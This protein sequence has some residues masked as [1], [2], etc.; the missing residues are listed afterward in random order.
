[1]HAEIGAERLVHLILENDANEAHH[2][3]RG[4]YAAQW[5]DDI[6]H[7]LHVLCTGEKDGYYADYAQAPIA[8]LGRCLAEGFAYQGERSAYRDGA[9][10]GEASAYLR[11]QAFVSF[12]QCHD[13]VGNRAFG[14]RITRLAPEPAVRVAVAVY[15]LAPTVPMLFMGEEFAAET[16]FQFFCD[17][18]DEL[19][20]TVTQGRRREFRKFARFADP[21]VLAAIPDP[22]RA[23]TF[24]A[25]KLDWHSLKE[26]KHANWLAYYRSLLRLRR[27]VIVPRLRGM[28][29]HAAAFDVLAPGALRVEWRL[30]DGSTLRLQTNFSAM[31][32][33]TVKPAGRTV[34]ASSAD[35]AKGALGPWSVLWTLEDGKSGA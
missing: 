25:S 35:A 5:N 1:V 34:F 11:P 4:H 33:G 16:P 14:E 23:E 2:L 13:Q 9:V 18:G 32:A 31:E 6:H 22:N 10:R 28:R 24:L 8:Q 17:F 12:L 30:G 20:D 19:R 21:A 7:A 29:G 27:D 26:G 15:L 3:G